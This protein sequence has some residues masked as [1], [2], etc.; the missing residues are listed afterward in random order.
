VIT[1]IGSNGIVSK[2]LSA[3]L[4]GMGQ[5]LGPIHKSRLCC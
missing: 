2:N 3:P 1:I 5:G 4:L